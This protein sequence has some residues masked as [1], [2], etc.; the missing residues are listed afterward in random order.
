[1]VAEA[2]GNIDEDTMDAQVTGT[3]VDDVVQ[4][5]SPVDLPN[6]C[7]VSITLKPLGD[8][9]KSLAAWQ[10][11]KRRIQERP[12]HSGRKRFTRDELHERR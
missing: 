8:L 7:R 9:S 5:D 10:E 1:L 3:L 12:V 4:L 6:H 11:L 2:V